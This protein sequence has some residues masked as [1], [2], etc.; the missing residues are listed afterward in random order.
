MGRKK[1]GKPKDPLMSF[2]VS[3]PLKIRLRVEAAQKGI[4]TSALV[5]EILERHFEER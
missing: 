2:Q 3:N 5:R 4:S 1:L